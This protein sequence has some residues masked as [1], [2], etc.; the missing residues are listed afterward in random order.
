MSTR[1]MIG[2]LQ[3]DGQVR[4]IYSHHDGYIEHV[5][6]VL[7]GHYTDPAKIDALLDLGDIS[8]L[9]EEIGEKHD[10]DRDPYKPDPHP[11]WT[12]AYGRD[13]GEE[14]V[15]AKTM[16]LDEYWALME[17]GSWAEFLYLYQ[18]GAWWVKDGKKKPI[19]LST[20]IRR[21]AKEEVA[22]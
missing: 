15:A 4:C 8:A 22:E 10:F 16:P 6:E 17:N 5:G 2:K 18:D 12:L 20:A 9:Y 14:N 3:D 13:R 11:T 21:L 7:A 1:S 19:K